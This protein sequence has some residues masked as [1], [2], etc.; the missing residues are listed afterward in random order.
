MAFLPLNMMIAFISLIMLAGNL[1]SETF[2]TDCNVP[3]SVWCSSQ[4]IA[5]KCKVLNQCAAWK[6]RNQLVNFTLYYEALCPDCQNFIIKQLFPTFIKLKSIINLGLVPYGNAY[7]QKDGKSWKFTCQHGA[8]EC[9]V[10]ILETCAIHVLEDPNI[11]VK[12]IYDLETCMFKIQKPE[13]CVKMVM[14]H[15]SKRDNLIAC[16]NGTTGIYLEHQ[17]A[18]KTNALPLPPMYVPWVTLNGVHSEHIQRK[19][20]NNLTDLICETYQGKDKEKYCPGRVIS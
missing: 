15:I 13:K 14:K 5:D 3:P 16:A 18:L 6:S 10:N 20:E 19:A 12:F 11:Y 7:E 17:M 9:S 2:P 8:E 1:M 4:E